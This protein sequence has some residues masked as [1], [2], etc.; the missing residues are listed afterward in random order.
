MCGDGGRVVLAGG[1]VWMQRARRGGAGARGACARCGGACVGRVGLVVNGARRGSLRCE[2]A[3]EHVCV[4]RATR[5]LRRAGKE[6]MLA[7]SLGGSEI[8]WRRLPYM[9]S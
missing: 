2:G 7:V 1:C 3:C 5:E 6:C 8:R 4:R 9:L